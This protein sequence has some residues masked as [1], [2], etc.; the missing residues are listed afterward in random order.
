ME[1]G[2][3]LKELGMTAE[4]MDRLGK[5]F[6]DEKFRE[7]FREYAQELS[8]P[9]NRRR[10]EEEIKLL[11]QD[12]GSTIEFIHPEPFRAFKTCMNGSHKCFI[13]ICASEK[14]G[15]PS[16]TPK[17]LEDGRRGLCWALPHILHP[18]RQE[19]Y[20]KGQKMMIYVVIF[21]PDTLNMASK[22]K[23]FMGM[24]NDTAIQGIQSTFNVTL[25]RNNVTEIGAKFKGTPQTCVIR[26]PIPRSKEPSGK[27][28]H[29]EFPFPDEKRHPASLQSNPAGS[30]TTAKRCGA[31]LDIQP[32]K[33]KEPTKPNYTLKY[34]SYIDI[35]D[36]TC[37][38]YTAQSPRPKEIVVTIDVPLLKK[39]TDA[40][41]EVA[42][43]MLL[44][45]SKKPAYRLELP[46]AYPVDEERGEAKFNK[47][48]GQLTVTLPVLPANEAFEFAVGPVPAD[49]DGQVGN[50]DA[51]EDAKVQERDELTETEV[52]GPEEQTS[53][54][55]GEGEE[56]PGDVTMARGAEQS[57]S[58]EEEVEKCRSVEEETLQEP[59]GLQ[60]N[61]DDQQEDASETENQAHL[62]VATHPDCL[63]NR[64]NA[65]LNV[66]LETT[67][68][69]RTS[70]ALEQME[71]ETGGLKE[72]A[73]DYEVSQQAQESKTD[74]ESGGSSGKEVPEEHPGS[75]QKQ[76]RQD[77][78]EDELPTEQV[79]QHQ[80][81]GDKPPPAVLI[82]VDEDGRETIIS[83]HSTSAGFTFQNSLIYELD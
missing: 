33:P 47:Q 4:E 44:L 16:F 12:K 67:S 21:H 73:T 52:E 9:E 13:N 72:E 7:L 71:N 22:N 26:K 24:V 23:Q 62:D 70:D 54:G 74:E 65:A 28:A 66:S 46:L 42:E 27:S 76:E 75:P 20:K 69:M 36:F 39:V 1:M 5:A 79:S 19:I 29:Q 56:G 57:R 81:P 48:K 49:G 53:E 78:D 35:Q 63:E 55:T 11:E 25:D 59:R 43:R 40:S 10:Y 61:T 37:S 2:N 17:V 41:L 64:G 45:E 60:W 30:A 50:G 51:E 83:D 80:Q 34:R 8:D 32:P 3:K 77:T 6:K 14:I 18:E 15:K 38:S 58:Q 82:E 31:G 68:K